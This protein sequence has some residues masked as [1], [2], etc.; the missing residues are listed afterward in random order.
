MTVGSKR[1]VF[2][3]TASKTAGGV[4][5]GGLMKTDKGRIVSAAKHKAAL[6]GPLAAWLAAV[7]EAKTELK[8]PLSGPGSF[9]TPTKGTAL[10]SLAKKIQARNSNNLASY[11]L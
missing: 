5:A 9:V 8:I 2:H 3:G 4:T 11:P 1:Q 10:Y 6:Q 7:K